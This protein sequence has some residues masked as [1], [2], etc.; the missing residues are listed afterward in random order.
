MQWQRYIKKAMA[1]VKSNGK[2]IKK[3]RVT[4]LNQKEG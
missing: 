4:G 2:H 1:T 3:E